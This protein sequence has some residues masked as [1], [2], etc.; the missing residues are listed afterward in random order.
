MPV[1]PML[2]MVTCLVTVTKALGLQA[3]RYMKYM[4]FFFIEGKTNTI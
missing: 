1:N 4:F 3:T 2:L